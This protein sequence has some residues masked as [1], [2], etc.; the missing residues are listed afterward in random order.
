MC[1]VNTFKIVSITGTPQDKNT[2]VIYQVSGKST[3]STER[4]EILIRELMHIRGFSKEDSIFIH[5]LLVAEVLSC[6]FRILSIMFDDDYVK[7]EIED[8]RSKYTLQLTTEEIV[9]SN[10][11]LK[12]FSH[13]DLAMIYYQLQ[14]EN[15][16]RIRLIKS[17]LSKKY[18]QNIND[19]NIYHLCNLGVNE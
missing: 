9:E 6:D 10:T 11:I 17:K 12:K 14:K 5:N 2:Q 16:T 19:G 8:I 4:P 7:F 13:A 3:I 15:E 1:P 18:Q